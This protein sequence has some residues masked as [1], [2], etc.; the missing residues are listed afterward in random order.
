MLR[1]LKRG[2]AYWISRGTKNGRQVI[3]LSVKAPDGVQRAIEAMINMGLYSDTL[4]T[5]IY[6]IVIDVA[7]ANAADEVRKK[8]EKNGAWSTENI[9]MMSRM[10]DDEWARLVAQ[11]EP[12]QNDEWI[13]LEYDRKKGTIEALFI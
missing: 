11:H 8:V 3:L 13:C 2:E 1:K 12:Y 5:T 4:N 9:G 6:D 7:D 10:D